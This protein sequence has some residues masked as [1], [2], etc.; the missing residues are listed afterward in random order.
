MLAPFSHWICQTVGNLVI[1]K[2]NTGLGAFKNS[3]HD[4]IH[5]EW[6][7]TPKKNFF[8]RP[9]LMLGNLSQAVGAF[10]IGAMGGREIHK[11]HILR[12]PK[13]DFRMS[14]ADRTIINTEVVFKA[15]AHIDFFHFHHT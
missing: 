15:A 14:A 11:F 7:G 6:T 10:N 5:S 9:Q 1:H 4:F 8:V 12:P 3:L 2:G 13:N